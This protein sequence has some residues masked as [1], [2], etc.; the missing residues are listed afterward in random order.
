MSYTRNIYH[1]IFGTKNRECTISAEYEQELYSYIAGIVK[2]KGGFVHSINGMPDHVHIVCD[3]PPVI[4]ISD[5][6]KSLKQSSSKWAKESGKFSHW[7]GWA[8][9]YAEFTCSFYNLQR[10]I[11]YVNNQKQHHTKITFGNELRGI[12]EDLKIEYD[13]R[14][15]PR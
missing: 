13:E 14:F 8:E 11:A 7:N 1:I 6:M 9:G 10:V 4:A 2:G 12:F 3:I 15:L 5:F